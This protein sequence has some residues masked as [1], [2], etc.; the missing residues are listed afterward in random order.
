MLCLECGRDTHSPMELLGCKVPWGWAFA[1]E[2]CYLIPGC[3]GELELS[4][5]LFKYGPETVPASVI[6]AVID[7]PTA[8]YKSL[9]IV[10]GC[11]L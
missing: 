9:F 2:W 4:A 1:Q 8:V 11:V 3:L 10:G 6:L 5:I 7:P